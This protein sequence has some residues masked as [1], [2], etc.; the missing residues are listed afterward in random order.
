MESINSD[1]NGNFILR[2]LFWEYIF[3]FHGINHN[4]NN[5]NNHVGLILN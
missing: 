5:V 4:E 1:R 3:R 2:K